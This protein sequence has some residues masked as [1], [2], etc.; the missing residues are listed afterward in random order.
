MIPH[1]LS[2]LLAGTR[3]N[4]KI[5]EIQ[6]MLS[7]LPIQLR[8]LDDFPGLPVVEEVGQTYEANSGLKA[9]TYAKWTGLPTL[10]DDSGLEVEDLG[11][12]P[13]P[14]SARFGGAAATDVD[15]IDKLLT[16]LKN[17]QLESRKARFVCCMTL[18]GWGREKPRDHFNP[19]I[20][21][22]S[23]GELEGR[24]ALRPQGENGFGYDP[25]FVPEGYDVT[26]AELPVS[27]KNRFSHRARALAAMHAFLERWATQT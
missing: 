8:S 4:G 3:N 17:T 9:M 22:V 2:Q 5:N 23:R 14:L 1:S 25:I 26:L 16:A 20:L 27:L 18:A 15:R 13:G 24:I 11:G 21:S 7:G 10:A 6:Q 12:N 19:V